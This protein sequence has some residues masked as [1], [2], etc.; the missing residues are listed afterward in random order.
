MA[1]SCALFSVSLPLHA[2]T[3]TLGLPWAE[4]WDWAWMVGWN[5]PVFDME[6]VDGAA[7]EVVE[8]GIDVFDAAGPATALKRENTVAVA[9]PPL[10]MRLTSGQ[11]NSMLSAF[12]VWD[13]TRFFRPSLSPA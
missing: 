1:P 2:G 5:R 8:A 7:V 11:Q 13:A 4:M 3:Y 10:F 6:A 12:E 9:I